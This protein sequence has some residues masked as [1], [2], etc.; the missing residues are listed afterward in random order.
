MKNKLMIGLLIVTQ[1]GGVMAAQQ[2]VNNF[3]QSGEVNPDYDRPALTQ[4]QKMAAHAQ[5]VSVAQSL[6]KAFVS[7]DVS[8]VITPDRVAKFIILL[9]FGIG[10]AT[11]KFDLTP[12]EVDSVNNFLQTIVTVIDRE[13]VLENIKMS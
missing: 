13:K 5:A 1:V 3:W 9:N 8:T 10:L 4:A 7:V 2:A 12:K 11:K 6:Q